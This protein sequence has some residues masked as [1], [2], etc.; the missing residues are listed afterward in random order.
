MPWR[1][2]PTLGDIVFAV[3]VTQASESSDPANITFGDS[4]T[5]DLSLDTGDRTNDGSTLDQ[6]LR[7]LEG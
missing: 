5:S 2:D 7:I 6:G 3:S 1:F 4:G